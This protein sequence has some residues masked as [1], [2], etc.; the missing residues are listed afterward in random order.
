M[1]AVQRL[2]NT[3]TRT[4]TPTLDTPAAGWIGSTNTAV[5]GDFVTIDANGRV[6]IAVAAGSN[7]GANTTLALFAGPGSVASGTATGTT[8]QIEY[9]DNNTR[10]ELQA[11]DNAGA[12]VATTAAMVGDSYELRNV[13]GIYCVDTAT[14]TNAKVQVVAISPRYAVG[15]VGGTLICK[16]VP[17]AR[18][19]G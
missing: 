10:I 14:T 2:S 18:I 4:V 16:V 13:G 19:G 1:P 5:L 11:V 17:A 7:V 6:T 9:F 8:V 12:P 3:V 15:E